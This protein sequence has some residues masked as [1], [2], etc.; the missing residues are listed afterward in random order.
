[1]QLVPQIV[2]KDLNR[3]LGAAA[4][5]PCGHDRIGGDGAMH[6]SAQRSDAMVVTARPRCATVARI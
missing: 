4:L 2:V 5:T 1:M 6:V 3:G